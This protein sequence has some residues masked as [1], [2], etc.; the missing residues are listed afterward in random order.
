MT[1]IYVALA[2][3]AGTWFGFG[4]CSFM[5]AGRLADDQAKT[6]IERREP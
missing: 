1:L 3:I 5:V 6:F 4:V 2:F